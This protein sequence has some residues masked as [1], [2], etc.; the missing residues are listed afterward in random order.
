MYQIS[1]DV[2]SEVW[3]PQSYWSKIK[4]LLT[5]SNIIH[6]GKLFMVLILA[7]FTGMIAGIKQLAQFSLRY[8]LNYYSM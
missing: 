1:T 5:V 7:S 6:L 8:A 4:P 3:Q 2:L